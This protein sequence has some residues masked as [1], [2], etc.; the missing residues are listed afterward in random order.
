MA[1]GN[2]RAR[3]SNEGRWWNRNPRSANIVWGVAT[4]SLGA[5]SASMV[6]G[7]TEPR[8][9]RCADSSVEIAASARQRLGHQLGQNAVAVLQ[10]KVIVRQ[11]DG[12][13]LSV[14]NPLYEMGT[15]QN[16]CTEDFIAGLAF[17]KRSGHQTLRFV[18][19]FSLNGTVLPV[20]AGSQSF[21]G[22]SFPPRV[23]TGAANMDTNPPMLFKRSP[24]E[25]RPALVE[26]A[27]GQIFIGQ[28]TELTGPTQRPAESP[29]ATPS[30]PLTA[31]LPPKLVQ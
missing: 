30:L 7:A 3:R 26:G 4:A 9:G 29:T 16:G 1:K 18:V 11:P 14:E 19:P 24:T 28:V 12:S 25:L 6:D 20:T 21:Q 27:T 31:T 10:G 8:T 17:D 5:F 15:A 13:R 23:M 2:H 22:E